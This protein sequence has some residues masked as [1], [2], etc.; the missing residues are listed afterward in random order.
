MRILVSALVFVFF[1]VAPINASAATDN[2][3]VVR[4]PVVGIELSTATGA[5]R[6]FAWVSTSRGP[7]KVLC[8]ES[9]LGGCSDLSV[10]ASGTIPSLLYT[11]GCLPLTVTTSG[12]ATY[13]SCR[14]QGAGQCVA[15][16]G[17]IQG[18]SFGSITTPTATALAIC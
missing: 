2:Q 16:D 9:S 7:I 10:S 15:L 18:N 11:G 13:W 4:G 3:I 6:W 17:Y 8:T 12:T 14:S 5:P 1:V